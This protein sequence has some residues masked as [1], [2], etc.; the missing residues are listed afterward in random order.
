MLIDQIFTLLLHFLLILYFV[1]SEGTASNGD[2]TCSSGEDDD[3]GTRSFLLDPLTHWPNGVVPYTI[4]PAFSQKQVKILKKNMNL[5]ARVSCVRWIPRTN[6]KDYVE[7]VRSQVPESCSTT[8][9]RIGGRQTLDLGDRCFGAM[10]GYRGAI[11]HEMLHTLGFIHEQQ[12]LDRDCF[13]WVYNKAILESPY[14]YAV[15]L[16]TSTSFPYDVKSIMHYPPSKNMVPIQLG[17]DIGNKA[18][19]LS[20]MDKMKLNYMYCGGKSYCEI[21]PFNCKIL[22][23]VVKR[24]KLM[25]DKSDNYVTHEYRG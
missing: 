17:E 4:D 19:L 25:L 7:I 10:H 16:D 3:T 24:C 22:R 5:L 23:Q 11:R 2:F 1:S 14:D 6:Q 8:V 12:R 9:G 15:T 20:K 21:D 18:G 13:V